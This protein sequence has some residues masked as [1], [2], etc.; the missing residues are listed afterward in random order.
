[1][2][3]RFYSSVGGFK[4]HKNKEIL[5]KAKKYVTSYIVPALEQDCSETL[6][7]FAIVITS[8][9]SYGLID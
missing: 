1:M 9:V 5:I 3:I 4:M 6:K 7:H 2:V 8:S